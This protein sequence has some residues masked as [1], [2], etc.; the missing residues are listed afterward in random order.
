MDRYCID[1]EKLEVRRENQWK[2]VLHTIWKLL[3]Q[4][5]IEIHKLM[6][7]FLLSFN[8]LQV[9]SNYELQV[10]RKNILPD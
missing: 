1:G 7:F 10:S 4:L 2:A 8:Y 5:Q 9:L 3:N 6:Q